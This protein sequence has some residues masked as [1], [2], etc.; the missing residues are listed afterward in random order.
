MPVNTGTKVTGVLL[1]Y[2][3]EPDYFDDDEIMLLSELANDLSVG[4]K[5]IENENNLRKARKRLSHLAFYDRLTNL[6]NS[7]SLLEK[8]ESVIGNTRYEQ[9]ALIM[10]QINGFNEINHVL[11]Y[12]RGDKML[13][14][15]SERIR[16]SIWPGHFAARI[17]GTK[18]AV[19]IPDVP[20]VE[21]IILLVRGLNQQIREPMLVQNIPIELR[22]HAGIAISPDHG[23]TARKLFRSADM[24]RVM[25]GRNHLPYMIYEPNM[26]TDP[27]KLGLAAELRRAINNHELVLYYQPK[28]NLSD[29]C[30]TGAEA[31]VRWLHP[32]RGLIPPDEFVNVAENTGIITNITYYVLE[33]AMR[34]LIQFH[35]DVAGISVAINISGRGLDNDGFTDNIEKTL[36]KYP[37]NPSSLMLE[38]TET[39]M[40]TDI[41]QCEKRLNDVQKYGVKVA[42]DDFGTGYSSLSYLAHLPL[43]S[44]KIDKS[45]VKDMPTM[46]KS[47]SIVRSTIDMGRNLDLGVTAEGIEELEMINELAG[48]GCTEG[49]GFGIAKPM[50]VKDFRKWIKNTD[51]S[52]KQVRH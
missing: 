35:K 23:K 41:K 8:A 42:V 38:L 7:A 44:L 47:H 46:E 19:L 51:F 39:A 15:I 29:R 13:K 30:V 1:L 25:S 10:L 22:L 48:M 5:K 11:G 4:I 16:E 24:A 37:M 27:R 28:I 36:E 31:L 33:N 49:Q 21:Q 32:E 2:A 43:D 12:N 26:E 17:A 50:P 52:I 6:P 20:S 9:S 14:F 45:F 3:D 40:M 18:F 34:D